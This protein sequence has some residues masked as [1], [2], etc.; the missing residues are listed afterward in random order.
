MQKRPLDLLADFPV[1][2]ISDTHGLVR[3]EALDALKG[4]RLII[5]AGDVGKPYVLHVLREMAPVVAVRGNVDLGEW[6]WELPTSEVV[7]FEG[8][9]FHI[10]HDLDRLELDPKA[11]GFMGVV[12][13]HSHLPLLQ[14]KN[15]IFYI[16]PGSAGPRRFDL[17]VTVARLR[18]SDRKVDVR[19]VDLAAGK[20]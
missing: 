16:N 2:L 10:V 20:N 3:Q 19:F 9:L 7:D 1:G 17:P 5:H 4:C 6:A 14:E 12:Y 11:A 13:G 15:G 8:N 18:V